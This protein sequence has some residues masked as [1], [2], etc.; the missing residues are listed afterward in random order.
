MKY[1]KLYES[2]KSRTI[3]NVL[4]Y[5]KKNINKDNSNKFLSDIKRMMLDFKVPISDIEDEDI[6]YLKKSKA[7][8][9][10]PEITEPKISTIKYWFSIEEGYLGYTGT[11]YYRDSNTVFNENDINYIKNNISEKCKLIPITDYNELK[12]LDI[13]ILKIN[14]KIVKS[15][16]VIEDNGY[17]YA[18]QNE[19]SGS[20]PEGSRRWLEYGRFSWQIANKLNVSPDHSKLHKYIESDDLLSYNYT[21]KQ[22][23]IV[24]N[25]NLYNYREEKEGFIKRSDFCIIFYINDI[26]NKSN[27]QQLKSNRKENKKYIKS[28]EQIKHENIERYLNKILS[29]SLDKDSLLTGDFLKLNKFIKNCIFGKFAFISLFN[30][31]TGI[32]LIE[33]VSNYLFQFIKDNEIR[34]FNYVIEDYTSYIKSSHSLKE[35]YNLSL[36][37]V[38]G[39]NNEKISQIFETINEISEIILNYFTNLKIETIKDLKFS[40]IKLSTFRKLILDDMFSLH[41]S[42]ILSRFNDP[43]IIKKYFTEIR[44]EDLILDED[45]KIL[46]LLKNYTKSFFS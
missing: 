7:I 37:V 45:I 18:I 13:I 11:G 5:I 32:L 40:Y 25:C 19:C 22:N 28:N 17:K 34:Y 29:V 15:T 43:V 42:Y 24:D 39:H 30:R 36:S 4:E 46:N 35:N 20:Q 33:N 8:N 6:K 44:S 26:L 23:L 21:S 27:L 9:L 38:N 12:D 10:F 1:L 41:I 16:L 14:E 2:F 31:S 3:S